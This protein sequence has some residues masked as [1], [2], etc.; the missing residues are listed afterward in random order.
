L[1]PG[2]WETKGRKNFPSVIHGHAKGKGDNPSNPAAAKKHLPVHTKWKAP[3]H[4]GRAAPGRI[5]GVPA[6]VF[7]RGGPRTPQKLG[8]KGCPAGPISWVPLKSRGPRKN[9]ANSSFLRVFPA[10]APA[11][12]QNFKMPPGGNFSVFNWPMPPAEGP[13]PTGKNQSKPRACGRSLFLARAKEESVYTKGIK[14]ENP[15]PAIVGQQKT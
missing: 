15:T 6:V 9:S 11:I 1:S 2:P 14:E 4:P 3:G 13:G 5:L 12:R 8:K 10:A 7:F